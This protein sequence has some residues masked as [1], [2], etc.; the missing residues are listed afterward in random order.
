MEY[1]EEVIRVRVT[2]QQKERL[3]ALAQSYG[4]RTADFLRLV[5]DHV[6]DNPPTFRVKPPVATGKRKGVGK[7]DASAGLGQEGD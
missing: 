2:K 7:G 3:D 6:C 4:K 5:I 1:F